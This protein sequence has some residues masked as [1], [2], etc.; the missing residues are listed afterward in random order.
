MLEAIPENSK[1]DEYVVLSDEEVHPASNASAN[2]LRLR[3]E[4]S[5]DLTQVPGSQT[6]EVNLDVECGDA[7]TFAVVGENDDL[8]LM[9][10]L[11][12]GGEYT[13]VSELNNVGRAG[14]SSTDI[15]SAD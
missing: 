4:S 14:K 13:E 9:G 1:D 5:I 12:A 11:D 3:E 7:D 10:V 2:H 8:Q 6:K 15:P